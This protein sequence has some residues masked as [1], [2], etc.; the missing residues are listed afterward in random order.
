ML[1]LVEHITYAEVTTA[2][3]GGGGGGGES[4]DTGQYADKNSS[5]NTLHCSL[6]G[7]HEV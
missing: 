6:H 2:G 7:F 5:A 4:S 1:L 3:G